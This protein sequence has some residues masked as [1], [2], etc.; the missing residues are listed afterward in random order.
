MANY[1]REIQGGDLFLEGVAGTSLRGQVTWKMF[2]KWSYH[3]ATSS[4]RE[5]KNEGQCGR[6]K[7]KLLVLR[8]HKGKVHNTILRYKEYCTQVNISKELCYI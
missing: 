7:G 1:W 2:L 4:G 8:I 3:F 6:L 5:S